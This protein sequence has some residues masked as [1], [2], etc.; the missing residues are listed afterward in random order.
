[1]SV[2]FGLVG[3]NLGKSS[4]S[5]MK[6]PCSPQPP[7]GVAVADEAG[8]G[9]VA[10]GVEVVLTFDASENWM[11]WVWVGCAP[12]EIVAVIDVCEGVFE[13]D[14]AGARELELLLNVE[15]LDVVERCEADE[16]AAELVV[17]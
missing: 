8:N 15:K 1:M 13:F 5:T 3:R 9:M 16:F 10:L 2:L 12:L 14:V 4:K 11:L 17:T 7:V 6:S